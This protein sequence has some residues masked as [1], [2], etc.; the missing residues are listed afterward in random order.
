VPESALERLCYDFIRV[1]VRALGSAVVRG[2]V[3][4]PA[5]VPALLSSVACCHDRVLVHSLC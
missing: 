4:E 2:P 1:A 5:N 3:P